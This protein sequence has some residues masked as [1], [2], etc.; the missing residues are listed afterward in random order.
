MLRRILQIGS[1]LMPYL[2][3]LV[4]LVD[5]LVLPKRDAVTPALLTLRTDV[6]SDLRKD[7]RSHIAAL[8]A[9]QIDITP[10]IEEQQRRL[11]KLEE[12]TAEM[13]HTLTVL[14]D[15]Q[16]DLAE[17]VRAMASWVR[18]CAMAG[19]FLLTLLFILKLVQAIHGMGH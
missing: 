9:A 3:W 7:M 17:Q 4:P 5:R 2:A 16:L 10:A 12:H 8:Q 15:D 14:S 13:T 19:L 18:N 1:G 6:R 11:E